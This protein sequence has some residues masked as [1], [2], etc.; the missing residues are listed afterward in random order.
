MGKVKE[1]ALT[2]WMEILKDVAYDVLDEFSFENM[3][4]RMYFQ[5][6]L[7]KKV[8]NFFSWSYPLA[9]HVKM[10]HKNKEID[11]MLSKPVRDMK[12]FIFLEGHVN[13]HLVSKMHRETDA[14]IDDSE[15]VGREKEKLILTS[16]L[17]GLNNQEILL[18]IP[19]VGIG[20]LG[21]MIL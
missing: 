11:G 6:R 3:R 17:I 21:K 19:I 1:G 18:L 12:M 9:F 5:K 20:G 13:D 2:L 7:M 4:Q 10:A 16:M 14:H 15:F 8:F